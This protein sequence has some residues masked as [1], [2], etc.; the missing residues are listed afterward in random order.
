MVNGLVFHHDPNTSGVRGL[1]PA[2]TV[3][4]LSLR[5]QSDTEAQTQSGG[6]SRWHNS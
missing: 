4:R 1:A 5:W 6:R 2:A 3:H